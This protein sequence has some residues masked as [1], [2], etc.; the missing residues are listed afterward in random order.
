MDSSQHFADFLTTVDRDGAL[1]ETR[2]HAER[3]LS[4][5]RFFGLTL[6]GAGAIREALA[7]APPALHPAYRLERTVDALCSLYREVVAA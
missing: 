1:A 5:R 7:G 3:T 2:S 4:R 6:A